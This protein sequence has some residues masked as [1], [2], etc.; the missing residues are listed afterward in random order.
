MA[1]PLRLSFENAT[2]HITARGNRR[3]SIFYSEKDRQVFLDKMNETFTKYSFILYAY[4]L[5]DNHYHL[6]LKTP[7]ANLTDGMHYLNSSY[8]NWFRTKY[9]IAGAVFQ[10]RYRSVLVEED[11]YALMLSAYIHL[12]PVRAG[13]VKRIEEYRWSSFLDYIGIRKTTIKRLDTSFILRQLDADLDKAAEKYKSFVIGNIDMKSPFESSYKGI[14]L[15]NRSFIEKIKEKIKSVGQ[16]REIRETRSVGSCEAEQ[17]I[18]KISEV[19]EIEKSKIFSK[20][21]GNVY[22]SLALYLIKK[23]STLSLKEM[24][25][26]FNMD[27]GAIS[28]AVKRFENKIKKDRRALRMKDAIVES[29]RTNVKC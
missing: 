7:L 17:I 5:M 21:R 25:K 22:R 8:A 23:Y 28:Q 16:K 27:Y 4:C 6:F 11:N 20:Q 19:F 9:K 2:Y 13:M 10:G 26:L 12:N 3:E 14:A 15:G 24:G 1:R 18:S 29:L